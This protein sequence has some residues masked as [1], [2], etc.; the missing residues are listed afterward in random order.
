MPGACY[1]FAKITDPKL[2]KS[3]MADLQIGHQLYQHYVFEEKY[4]VKIL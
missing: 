2:S 4:F 1:F 3:V